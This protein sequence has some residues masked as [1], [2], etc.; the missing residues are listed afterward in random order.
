MINLSYDMNYFENPNEFIKVVAKKKNNAW[1]A[2]PY[3]KWARPD[4]TDQ[5]ISGLNNPGVI[6]Y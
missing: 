5:I 2:N 4:Q 3:T 1:K 6:T